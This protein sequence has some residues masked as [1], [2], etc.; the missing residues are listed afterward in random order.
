MEQALLSYIL[1]HIPLQSR[2]LFEYEEGNELGV[3]ENRV[4]ARLDRGGS[5]PTR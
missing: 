5:H 2:E 3:T 1:H 4:E